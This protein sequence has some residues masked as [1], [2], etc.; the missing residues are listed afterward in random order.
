MKFKVYSEDEEEEIGEIEAPSRKEALENAKGRIRAG[1]SFDYGGASVIVTYDGE[2]V[3][4]LHSTPNDVIDKE[5]DAVLKD[6]RDSL[7]LK[8]VV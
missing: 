7:K 4:E 3:V 8:E 1:V 2:E 5:M 6:A